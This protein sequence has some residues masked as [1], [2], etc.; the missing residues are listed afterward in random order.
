MNHDAVAGVAR[1]RTIL[2]ADGPSDNL[3][4]VAVVAGDDAV[5]NVKIAVSQIGDATALVRAKILAVPSVSNGDAVD[6]YRTGRDYY[7]RN[8]VRP[9]VND[10]GRRAGAD[11]VDV[12]RDL[13]RL[14]IGSRGKPDRG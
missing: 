7:D 11:D 13:D 2:D 14:V 9:G 12:V 5:Q 1:D 4:S 8:I 3:H 10:R 6:F